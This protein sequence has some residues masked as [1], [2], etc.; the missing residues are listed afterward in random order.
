MGMVGW[1]SGL[2]CLGLGLTREE[3]VIFNQSIEEIE[4]LWPS[5]YGLL[6]WAK[7]ST[8]RSMGHQVGY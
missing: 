3:Q 5:G 6:K 2:E 1:V 8:S 4:P 7:F